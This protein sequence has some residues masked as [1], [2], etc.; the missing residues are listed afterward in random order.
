MPRSNA[1]RAA[2]YPTEPARIPIELEQLC[3]RLENDNAAIARSRQG[4]RETLAKIRAV[5]ARRDMPGVEYLDARGIK[6]EVVREERLVVRK[7]RR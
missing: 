2:V 7:V 1:A 6:R 4:K 3:R 5:L